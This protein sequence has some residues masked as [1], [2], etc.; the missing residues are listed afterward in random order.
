MKEK[1]FVI[2]GHALCYRAY[3]AFINN[4]LKN[5]KGQ[6]TSAIFGFFRMFLKLICEQKPNY[7]AI[8]FDPPCK[9]FRFNLF[10]DYKANRQKMPDDLR[11]QIEEIKNLVKTLGIVEIIEND[12]EADDVLGSIAKKYASDKVEVVLVTGDKDAYQLVNENVKI[13]ANTKGISEFEIYDIEKVYAKLGLYPKDV[14]DYMA[15]TGDTADNIPGIKGVGPKS[16]Q[17]LIADYKNLEGIFS[18]V[19]ELKGKL[20]ELVETSKDAAF[21]SRTLVTIK[22]DIALSFSL[23]DFA[24]TQIDNCVASDV[25][26]KLEMHSIVTEYF[27][28]G[29]QVETKKLTNI[30][31]KKDYKTVKTF[32]QLNEM[33]SEIL[34]CKIVS[35]DTE[36]TSIKPSEAELVGISFSICACNG[37]YVP[38]QQKTLFSLSDIEF[39]IDEALDV[40]KVIFDMKK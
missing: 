18:N 23:A 35:F 3:F 34:K 27:S 7:L 17:K 20:K 10:S 26:E 6:N 14:I 4:P 31:E 13:Y 29:E 37:W 40:L 16:A 36:T 11:S 15:L 8:A 19:N 12:Y 30:D 1:C 38:M 22:T 28:K 2:D 9:S 21:L 39:S 5:S 24:F 33:V 25:F 32:S